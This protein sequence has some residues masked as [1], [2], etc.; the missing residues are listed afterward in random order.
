VY[1]THDQEEAMAVSDRIA[2][3]NLG[4]IQQI[5]TPKALY[6]RPANLFVASF[7]GRTNILQGKLNVSGEKMEL[8]F[9][10][11]YS[12]PLE[13]VLPLYR[14]SG[15]VQVSV[16]PEEFVISPQGEGIRARIDDSVFLGLNTHYFVTTADGV[17]AEIVQESQIDSILPKGLDVNLTVKREKINVLTA[18]GAH[19]IL[20]G[21]Q[22]DVTEG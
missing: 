2:V 11:G 5:G 9:E 7:I 22:N 20:E 4:V 16:R 15:P 8:S 12:V 19:N 6:Q 17:K 14:K 10:G 13:H 18:D 21:V 1:V 3:M